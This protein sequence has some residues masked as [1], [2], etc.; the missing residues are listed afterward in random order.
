M[1]NSDPINKQRWEVHLDALHL[2]Q[3]V[4][5]PNII[6][7]LWTLSNNCSSNILTASSSYI[8]RLWGKTIRTPNEN[9]PCIQVKQLKLKMTIT[10]KMV[11]RLICLEILTIRQWWN[12]PSKRLV[13]IKFLNT[14]KLLYKNYDW[15]LWIY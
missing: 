15:F 12:V 4:P 2:M 1:I 14:Q 10:S 3:S 13:G 9:A 8:Y 11:K 7:G 6:W 5:P